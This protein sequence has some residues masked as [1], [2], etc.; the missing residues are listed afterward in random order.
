M[1]VQLPKYVDVEL[2]KQEPTYAKQLFNTTQLREKQSKKGVTPIRQAKA[3]VPDELILRMNALTKDFD[4]I[5]RVQNTK[6]TKLSWQ[7]IVDIVSLLSQPQYK[8]S[9]LRHLI[10][11][12]HETMDMDL[13]QQICLQ[14]KSQDH[15]YQ[16]IQILIKKV[17]LQLIPLLKMT[18]SHRLATLQLCLPN[19]HL[20]CDEIVDVLQTC[21]ANSDALFDAMT[22]LISKKELH[23]TQEQIDSIVQ[24]FDTSSQDMIRAC[25]TDVQ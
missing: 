14:F 8:L 3:L 20:T 25:F 5:T 12:W 4:R 23:W 17:K 7:S 9:A 10:P 6:V 13:L 18:D 2:H 24:L 21:F 1:N 16:V 19:V 15:I 22:C 11:Q